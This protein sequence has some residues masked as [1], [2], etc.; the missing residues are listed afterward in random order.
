MGSSPGGAPSTDVDTS[1]LDAELAALRDPNSQQNKLISS[2]MSG[3]LSDEEANA[4]AQ[5]LK[6]SQSG[7][8]TARQVAQ[9]TARE[10]AASRGLFSSDIALGAEAA[11][12]ADVEN[13]YA[14]N[15]AN[16]YQNMASQVKSGI[17][18]GLQASQN[19]YGQRAGLAQ[20][21]ATASYQSAGLAGQQYGQQLDYYPK[22]LTAQGQ[23]ISGLMGG[24]ATATSGGSGIMGLAS[25]LSDRALKD[26]IETIEDALETLDKLNPVSFNWK[27]TGKKDYG[28]IAQEIEEVLP[29]LVVNDDE[30]KKVNYGALIGILISAVQELRAKLEAK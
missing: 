13:Q 10:G 5:S 16:L 27:A 19:V 6:A 28:V 23:F 15:R 20:A 7:I 17:L 3:R 14:Q 30:Y 21:I 1:E 29:E 24:G 22:M 11:G 26:N 9:Q 8:N 4:F 2:L 25:M 12:L 18:S